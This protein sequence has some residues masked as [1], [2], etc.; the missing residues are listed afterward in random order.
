MEEDDEEEEVDVNAGCER[1]PLRFS[2]FPNVPPFV[3]FLEHGKEYHPPL[4]KE[5]K[6]WT[7]KAPSGVSPII[8]ESIKG[9]GFVLQEGSVRNKESDCTGSIW[10]CLPLTA[11]EKSKETLNFS[12]L[13]E[14]VKINQFPALFVIGRKDY[15]WT[16][17]Q[18]LQNKFGKEHFGF[19][20]KTYNLPDDKEA[21]KQE[22]GQ[23]K[24]WILKPPNWFCGIGIK[25]ITKM[26]DIPVRGGRNSN[27]K[28]PTTCIQEYINNPFL[29]NGVKFDLRIYV[30]LTSIDPIRVYIYEDGLVR[31]ATV[32]YTNDP[33]QISNNCIHLTNYSVNKTNKDFEYNENPGEYEGHKWSIKTLWKYFDEVLGIDWRP[34][35]EETK[36]ICAKT[37]L[38]GHNHIKEQFHK[39]VQ[40]EYTCYKLFGFDVFFDA[41]LKPWLLEVNNIPSLHNPTLDAHVNRPMVAE[42]F[43]IV[44]FHVPKP[45]AAKH[46]K[47]IHRQ[48]E[49]TNTNYGFLGYD[50]RLYT[51]D[52]SDEELIKFN[53]FIAANLK[54]EDYI[55]D[56]LTTLTPSDVR[57]LCR[58]EDELSACSEWTRIFPSPSSSQYLQFLESPSYSDRLLEAWEEMYGG[59]GKERDRGRRRLKEICRRGVNLEVR[60]RFL[61][62]SRTSRYD[63]TSYSRLQQINK[64]PLFVFENCG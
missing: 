23:E 46:G 37:I 42:M 55:S 50:R 39:N 27:K 19:L 12:I 36:E 20:P 49:V 58:S 53:K 7:W 33:D 10:D 13:S 21:L 17:F 41:N 48:L 8:S 18:R 44:G 57:T 59:S 1:F 31:F 26:S 61:P 25:L 54:K 11:T 32:P 29:I 35:W 63:F 34:I 28:E 9:A 2:L 56:I 3:R 45:L 16:N 62:S 4:P 64:N 6:Q 38:C 14:E 5:L 40:S 52:R 24:V 43:N 22:M 51:M 60:E 30:L 15:L 47:L